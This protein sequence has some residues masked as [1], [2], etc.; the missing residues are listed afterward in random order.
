MAIPDHV[1]RNFETL[2]RAA[3]S[4]N[5]GLVECVHPDTGEVHFLLCA[6]APNA[7]GIP[8]IV[9]ARLLDHN[10]FGTLLPVA[11]LAERCR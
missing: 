6:V 3:Q 2:G 10:P 7:S 5:L 11:G 8:G 4:G 1:A 9:F